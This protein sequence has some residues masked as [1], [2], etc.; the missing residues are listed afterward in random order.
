MTHRCEYTLAELLEDPMTGL[1]MKSDRVERATIES[2][3][4]AVQRGRLDRIP[5]AAVCGTGARAG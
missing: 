1:L 3:V 2:L 5:A 4:A